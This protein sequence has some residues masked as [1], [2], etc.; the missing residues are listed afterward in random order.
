VG[1]RAAETYSIPNA[2]THPDSLYQVTFRPHADGIA[3]LTYSNKNDWPV[4][5]WATC[6]VLE[7]VQPPEMKAICGPKPW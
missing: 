7:W 1:L 4:L 5:A 3:N 6:S 2:P